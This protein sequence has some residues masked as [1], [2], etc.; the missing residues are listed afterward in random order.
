VLCQRAGESEQTFQNGWMRDRTP[1]GLKMPGREG[2]A[3][4]DFCALPVAVTAQL[5]EVSRLSFSFHC[6]AEHSTP[7]K[8]RVFG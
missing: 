4:K 8:Y 7:M 2:M 6:I 5:S 3:L 1:D